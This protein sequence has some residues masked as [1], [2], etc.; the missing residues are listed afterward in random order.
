MFH[1]RDGHPIIPRSRRRDEGVERLDVQL[2]PRMPEQMAQEREPARVELALGCC[3]IRLKRFVLLVEEA[4]LLR[5]KP[6]RFERG[7]FALRS[8]AFLARFIQVLSELFGALG[9]V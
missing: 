5:I 1:K 8:I 6:G 9:L 7:Q 2:F 4:D 3:Q